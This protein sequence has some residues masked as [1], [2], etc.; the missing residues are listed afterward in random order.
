MLASLSLIGKNS[1]SQKKKS[2]T[3]NKSEAIEWLNNKMEDAK[4]TKINDT[5]SFSRPKFSS[6]SFCDTIEQVKF[7]IPEFKKIFTNTYTVSLGSLN[8]E[9][10]TLF[11]FEDKFFY[12]V[13]TTNSTKTI[14]VY[15]NKPEE[16]QRLIAKVSKVR[17]GPFLKAD[18]LVERVK[19]VLSKLIA[20]CG[21][22]KD[23]F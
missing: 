11:I 3:F 19:S 14:L 6:C 23:S 18:N 10:L 1:F 7:D 15:Y 22:K 13:Y 17:I 21:G 9:A 16:P 20:N 12:D 2:A 8:P 4:A 5:M